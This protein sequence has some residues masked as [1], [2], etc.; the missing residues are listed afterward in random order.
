MTEETQIQVTYGHT[1]LKPEMMVSLSLVEPTKWETFKGVLQTAK[2]H[3]I[4]AAILA[5]MFLC[6]FGS[7]LFL[8]LAMR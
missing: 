4:N 1:Y 5:V 2:Y 7:L 6:L 8:S 3:L